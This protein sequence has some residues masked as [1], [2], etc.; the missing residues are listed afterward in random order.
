M[1]YNDTLPAFI[2]NNKFGEGYSKEVKIPTLRIKEMLQKFPVYSKP[3]IDTAGSNFEYI[4]P[5]CGVQVA[6]G[7]IKKVSNH[8]FRELAG[9]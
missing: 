9:K 6:Q 2:T 3:P 8:N 7:H 5:S 4:N 1:K